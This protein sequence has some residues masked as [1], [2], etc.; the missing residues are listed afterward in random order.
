MAVQVQVRR[1]RLQDAQPIADFVNSAYAGHPVTGADVKGRFSQV[2]FM[3]AEHDGHIIGLLG[4]QVENLVIRVNDFLVAPALDRVIAGRALIEAMERE[5]L[6]L[7]AEAAIL[8]LPLRPSPD[9]IAYWEIFGYE[10]RE[11]AALPRAWREAAREWNA[12]ARQVMM[13]PLRQDLVQKPI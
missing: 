6:L 12:E 13:K 4:W 3:L 9:L 5:G 7:Q 2:G 8:L 1:A 11:V 10:Q